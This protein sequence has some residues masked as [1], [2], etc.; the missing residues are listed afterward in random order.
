MAE[1]V[2][3]GTVATV[4]LMG[5]AA[6][7]QTLGID[8][9]AILWG[10]FGGFFLLSRRSGEPLG[11]RGALLSLAAS[12]GAAGALSP[13]IANGLFYTAPFVPKIHLIGGTAFLVG[14]GA[15][16]LVPW[17]IETVPK[18]LMKKFGLDRAEEK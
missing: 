16:T 15:Q 3:S 4:T 14:A 13:P 12:I 10:G 6:F 9:T 17:M 1:P 5:L 11:T 8:G 2:S 7:L 18:W